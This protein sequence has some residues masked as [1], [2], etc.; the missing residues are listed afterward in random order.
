[1]RRSLVTVLTMTLAGHAGA[2]VKNPD[3]YIGLG[4]Y[5]DYT[6]AQ[7]TEEARKVFPRAVAC[8]EPTDDRPEKTTTNAAKIVLR[9]PVRLDEG[10]NLKSEET[11][12][13]QQMLTIEGAKYSGSMF[14]RVS[15]RGEQIDLVG[16]KAPSWEPVSAA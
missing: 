15:T 3:G 7:L 16:Q 2:T 9:W 11:A 6:C 8:S 13:R 5:R 4:R 10:V 14:Y 1:M 12:L